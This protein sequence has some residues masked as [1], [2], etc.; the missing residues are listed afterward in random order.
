M[1]QVPN[2]IYIYIYIYIH[3][4]V[5]IYTHT[6]FGNLVSYTALLEACSHAASTKSVQLAEEAAGILQLM[7]EV[8][9]APDA[10]AVRFVCLWVC[11]YV[12]LHVYA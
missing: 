1:R 4:Y 12:C 9:V 3:T 7:Q 2:H 10:K 8:G 6:Q 5:C 11:V